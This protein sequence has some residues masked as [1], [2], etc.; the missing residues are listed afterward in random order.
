MSSPV[1]FVVIA[2]AAVLAGAG[3]GWG[4]RQI[5]GSRYVKRA[6][7][8]RFAREFAE[9]VER[10]E[11]DLTALRGPSHEHV[12]V[13]TAGYYTESTTDVGMLAPRPLS[14]QD[15]DYYA[16]S[17]QNVQGEFARD[18][19]SGLLLAT[20]LTAN[21]LLNRGLVPI[22]TARPTELPESWT[23]P[24]ADGYR[25]ALDISA[26]TESQTVPAAALERALAQFEDFY[27]EMLTLAAA[28]N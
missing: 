8:R 12:A 6:A 20:H 2:A 28:A 3:L 25:Q 21:L 11:L 26:R 15:Q 19:S 4:A 9:L 7:A 17:W 5:V 13:A 22:D 1:V 14:P 24:S 23:F 27:F 10:T 18:P 16:A